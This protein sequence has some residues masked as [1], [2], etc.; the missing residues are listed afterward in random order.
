MARTRTI[1]TRFVLLTAAVLALDACSVLGSSRSAM[2]SRGGIAAGETITVEPNQN[3]YAI[4]QKHNVSMRELI[5]LND[6]KPPYNIRTGQSITLPATGETFSGSLKPPT[7]APRDHVEKSDLAPIAPAAVSR[8]VLE[9]PAQVQQPPQ[10]QTPI[11]L[12]PFS[13]TTVQPQSTLKPPT[14][15]PVHAL[16]QPVPAQRP[17]A[18]TTTASQAAA[19]VVD[20]AI[21]MK[22]PVQGTILSSYGAKGAGLNNDGINI[23]APKGAPVVAAATGTVVYAGNE[24]KGF[25]NLV[26]IR[27]QSDWVTAYAHLDRVM[28]KKD[29][30]VSRGDM[31][32]TVGKTG[33][34][35]SP[36][37]HFET[38][39]NGK[40]VDPAQ[41]IKQ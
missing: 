18:T 39:Q 26:L 23:G 9:P 16:N 21:D 4:A 28:V 40:P 35:S 1:L 2:P 32:G 5:V 3:I 36:Q 11:G 30:I 15:D 6:L 29:S 12:S 24:M 38:R 22:W 14:T 25:G 27:H 13:P 17:V 37:L 41:V 31:I 7:A 20:A 10:P 34:V 33:N 19:N 8:E